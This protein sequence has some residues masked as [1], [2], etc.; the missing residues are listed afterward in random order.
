VQ[1]VDLEGYASSGLPTWTM[2]R[3]IGQDRLFYAA[4]LASG[5]ALATA[6]AEARRE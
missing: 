1:P 4:A 3:E 6:A 5:R 2:G